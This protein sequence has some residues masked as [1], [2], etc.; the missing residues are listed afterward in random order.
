[1]II[2]VRELLV[3]A[4]KPFVDSCVVMTRHSKGACGEFSALAE[5]CLCTLLVEYVEQHAVFSLAWHDHHVIEI[6]CSSTDERYSAYIDLL[7]DV[8]LGSSVGHSLL[9]RIEIHDNEVYLGNLVLCHLLA[10]AF[11]VAAC[12]M[13]PNIF[14]CRVFT[15]PPR[16]EG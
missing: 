3:C 14:G 8:S 6:L 7:D 2:L 13:P 1:M 5:G 11:V 12:S 9:E 4:L 16:I 10:V 15:L